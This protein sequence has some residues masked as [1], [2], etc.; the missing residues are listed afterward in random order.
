[1]AKCVIVKLWNFLG[2]CLTGAVVVTPPLL[3]KQ[4]L[5]QM[6]KQDD[7]EHV[8]TLKGPHRQYKR[9]CVCVCVHVRPLW[10]LYIPFPPSTVSK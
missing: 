1:M 5:I 3:K 8:K 6:E 4:G 2:L 7:T 10:S 9:V